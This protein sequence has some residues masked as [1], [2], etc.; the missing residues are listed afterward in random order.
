M[1]TVETRLFLWVNEHESYSGPRKPA[2]RISITH[3]FKRHT[4]FTEAHYYCITH[5]S[6]PT[7][8]SWHNK[9]WKSANSWQWWEFFLW[10]QFNSGMKCRPYLQF[11]YA[12]FYSLAIS[13]KAQ[14]SL[15]SH[16]F[17]AKA[18]VK[19]YA[20]DDSHELFPSIHFVGMKNMTNI[21]KPNIQISNESSKCDLQNSMLKILTWLNITDKNKFKFNFHANCQI[22]LKFSSCAEGWKQFC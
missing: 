13:G 8:G 4:Y 16:S 19:K 2:A 20:E 5:C 10:F 14:A 22:V 18:S 9:E 17:H 1:Q 21:G 3:S 6:S 12:L 15:E 11:T 7:V